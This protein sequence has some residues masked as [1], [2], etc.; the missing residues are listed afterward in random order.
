MVS[1]SGIMNVGKKVYKYG[2]VVLKATPELTFGTS[3][4]KVGEALRAAA[5]SGA[6]LKETAKAG[7]KVAENVSKG[8]TQ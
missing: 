4:G 1:I 2:K 3:A 5:T 6:S 7:L 8:K